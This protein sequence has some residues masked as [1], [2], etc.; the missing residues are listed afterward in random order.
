MKALSASNEIIGIKLRIVKVTVNI[1]DAV[2]DGMVRA[3][4]KL[5]C[6]Q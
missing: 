2:Q 3:V 6:E 4:A 1:V 5:M